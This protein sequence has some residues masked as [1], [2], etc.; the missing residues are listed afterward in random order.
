MAKATPVQ[1]HQFGKIRPSGDGKVNTHVL[2]PKEVR[3]THFRPL[4]KPPGKAPFHLDLATVLPAAGLADIE[5]AQ[6]MTFHVNGDMGGISF[7][8]PQELVAKGMEADFVDGAAPSENPAFLYVLGDCVY[9]NGALDQYNPQFFVPYEHYPAP[10][11]AVPGNHD[12]ENIPPN[13]SLDGFLTCFCDTKPRLIPQAGD[14]GRTTMTQPNVYWVL[15]TPL[16]NFVGLYSNV[17]E[18]GDIREPQVAWLVDQLKNLPTTVPLVITLHHPIYSADIYHSGSSHMKS[19]LE[20][21]ATR[22]GRHPDMVL[23]GHVHDYQRITKHMADGTMIPYLVVGAGG[24][25]NLHAIMKVDGE[26]LITPTQFQDKSGEIVTLE[27]Y[28]DDNHGFLRLEVSGSTITGRY[29]TVPRPQDP[30]SKGS[31][32]LDYFEFDWK[33][34]QYTP[35]KL[36]ATGPAED[37]K[38]VVGRAVRAKSSKT[39]GTKTKR[40][41][42]A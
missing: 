23:A 30:Y 41:A 33:A 7:G 38:P 17:P 35:N 29:Y 39:A 36:M 37:D 5:H 22:A 19:I 13:I 40:K 11:F 4:P 26:K 21:A 34:R 24:Y 25:H 31:A 14:T 18:G 8:V 10:I 15:R 27:K 2:V 42:A 20:A 3:D 9:F 12:G 1:A 16:I 28:S 32:L 6:K